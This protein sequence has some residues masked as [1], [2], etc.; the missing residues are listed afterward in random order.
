MIIK[1]ENAKAREYTEVFAL[2]VSLLRKHN[3]SHELYQV[4]ISFNNGYNVTV[5]PGDN[6]SNLEAT[7]KEA[8]TNK[9]TEEV[10]ENK[11]IF[12]HPV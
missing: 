5:F 6:L 3:T 7:H 2:A 12:W 10:K 4:D 9:L 8:L 11:E 1:I